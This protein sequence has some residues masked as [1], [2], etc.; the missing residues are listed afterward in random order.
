MWIHGLLS[1]MPASSSNTRQRPDSERRD[2]T[3]Q[4]AEPAPVTM[5]SNSGMTPCHC[6]E[7]SDEANS[8]KLRA[9]DVTEI[10]SSLRSSQ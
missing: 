4:P 3:A 5:K 1:R 10:A 9:H 2:A 7:R 8:V 6:E